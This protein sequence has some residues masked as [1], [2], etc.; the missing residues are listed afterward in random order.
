MKMAHQILVLIRGLHMNTVTFIQVTLSSFFIQKR[1]VAVEKRK[2]TIKNYHGTVIFGLVENQVKMNMLLQ[3][4][5]Y[6]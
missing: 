1:K 2:V 5:S 3:L 4:V 6:S